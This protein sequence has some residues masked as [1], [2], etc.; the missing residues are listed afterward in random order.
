MAQQITFSAPD[1]LIPR[2]VAAIQDSLPET[3]SMSPLDAARLFVGFHIRSVVAQYEERQAMEAA[4][5]SGRLARDKAWADTAALI[6][7]VLAPTPAPA[8]A[9]A[10]TPA[11]P[12]DPTLSA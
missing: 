1:E 6:A 10:P 3:A 12:T 7:P 8:P 2:I 11:P 5:E 4:R 9:P